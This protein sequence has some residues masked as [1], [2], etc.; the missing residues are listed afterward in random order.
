M[1]CVYFQENDSFEEVE[2]FINDMQR[3]LNLKIIKC[4]RD[5]TTSLKYMIETH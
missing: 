3:F 2:T 5:F 4:E 1:D